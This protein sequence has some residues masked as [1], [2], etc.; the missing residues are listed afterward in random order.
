MKNH[1]KTKVKELKLTTL[2]FTLIE[3]LAVIVI[4]A[5]I[6]LIVVPQVIKIL[7]KARLSAAID[8]AYGI[9][10]SAESYVASFMLKNDGSLPGKDLEFDCS[11]TGCVLN[12]TDLDDYDLTNLNELN[13]KGVKP[14][15]GTVIIQNNGQTIKA[16]NLV[17]NGFTCNKPIFEDKV[18][19]EKTKST[20]IK[21]S[22]I[23]DKA[24][25]L[26]YENNTC[27]TDGTTYQYMGGCY[28][29]GASTNN[30]IWYNGFMW[31]IMGINSDNTVRLI[32]DE[33]V[34]TIPYGAR[35]TAETY[36]TN[37][38]YIHDWL[39][40]YFLGHLNS[41]KS[42][43]K[44]G[45]YF[46]SETIGSK[47]TDNNVRTT[48]TSGKEV[49]AKV[50]LISYDECYL[51]SLYSSYL[52]IM[53]NFWTMTP[54]SISDAWSVDTSG[55]ANISDVDRT[56]V[57]V[58]PVINV[59]ATSTITEGDGTSS[60]YYVLAEDKTSD[61]TGTISNIVTSGE[62][63][64]LEGKTYRVVSKDSDGVKLIYDGYYDTNISYGSNNIFTI[65]S[66]IGAKLNGDV[67]TWLGLNNSTKIK[68]TTWYQG[69]A[70]DRGY[71]YKTPLEETKGTG[72]EAKVGL[73]RVGEMLSG[74]SSTILTSNYTKTSS[75][76]YAKSYW[77]MNK[78]TSTSRAWVVVDSG[79]VWFV[80]MP[81]AYGVRP[82]IKVDTNLT[83]SKGNGT[84]SSP[85]EI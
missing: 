4:L 52:N 63:V 44:E 47:L 28:I 60:S 48:C 71:T 84:W 58:R 78:Y 40:T 42:I 64:K 22:T 26:V 32:T 68:E 36:A 77:T 55:N 50:G 80:D 85:Y 20:E 2:G 12:T 30:Y 3:L 24:K 21:N 53:Q 79:R 43:I 10:E 11:K 72:I 56:F 81:S 69:T 74:Q 41:T 35:G 46:C 67:L 73:I 33:N 15:K 25:S 19:C 82:V 14:E 70:M 57:G 29:K 54:R 13:F 1:L 31:R 5:I 8:S 39:N 17:I 62:Y 9:V 76:S 51:A 61:K 75:S 66:G 65:D 38:D 23:L 7:N 34:T 27:K 16:T 59:E 83:I 37:E 49:K 45:N 6:A 18:T